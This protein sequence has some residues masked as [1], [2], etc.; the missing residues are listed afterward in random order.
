MAVYFVT[1]KLGAG[2]TLS[3]VARIQEAL[4]RGVPVATN[5]DL[6]L[7]AMCGPKAKTPVVYRLPD[8]PS[9]A[10]LLVIGKGNTGYDERK[11]GLVVLD[12]CGTWFN[13]RTWGDK[14]RQDIIN[15]F[16]HARKLGWDIIF[17][18]QSIQVVDKQARLMLAEHVV[19]CRRL[20][21]LTIP[22]LS[23]ITK[24]LTGKL[25]HLPQLHVGV[26]KYGD[27]ERSLTVDRWWSWG[28]H[29]YAAY[30][31]KQAFSDY[32]EHSTY[33]VLTP[34]LSRGRYLMPFTWR[35]AMRMTKIYWRR[36]SRPVLAGAFFAA[37]VACAIYFREPVPAPVVVSEVPAVQGEPEQPKSEEGA[38]PAPQPP[39]PPPVAT[40]KQQY[41]GWRI[42][43]YLKMKDRAAYQVASPD[44]GQMSLDA[45]AGAELDVIPRDNCRVRVVSAVDVTDFADIFAPGCIPDSAEP[46][47]KD[48]IAQLPNSRPLTPPPG[49]YIP[50][51]NLPV[52]PQ[53]ERLTFAQGLQHLGK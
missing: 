12:E 10:D 29:L 44:G 43:G 15:W 36:F 38:A 3:S 2:K 46:V 24:L 40:V 11:N 42:I 4:A 28:G 34:W 33:Q 13:S 26:V 20:D 5:L 22:F 9:I 39:A 53:P 52:M 17:I 30:D 8:K 51:S 35:L 6:D 47:I 45:L 7:V 19:Y 32:Y 27:N 14:E 18:I 31:T 1:G 16:L 41:A 25:L 21:K 23:S 37:G 50:R 49:H 48:G